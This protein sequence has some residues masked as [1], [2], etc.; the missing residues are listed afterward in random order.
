M[1]RIKRKLIKPFVSEPVDAYMKMTD[2]NLASE[3]DAFSGS[4]AVSSHIIM[5]EAG[6]A[7]VDENNA[8][9]NHDAASS[10]EAFCQ[11][12]V[13]ANFDAN[14][15]FITSLVNH[16]VQETA[17][18]NE[19]D[20]SEE[21]INETEEKSEIN[22]EETSEEKFEEKSEENLK[23][24][25]EKMSENSEEKMSDNSEEKMSEKSEEKMSENSEEKMSE[26]SKENFEE[27][28]EGTNEIISMVAHI[29]SGII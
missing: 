23:E 18:D 1:S 25:N 10:V 6:Y 22:S 29:V 11:E 24:S 19:N 3:I 12:G 7:N 17:D 14:Y 21:M 20:V 13:H 16:T 8:D 27:N 28:S 4:D 26:N 9:A 2:A 15:R 5:G